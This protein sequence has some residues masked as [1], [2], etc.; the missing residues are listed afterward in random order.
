VTEWGRQRFGG[1]DVPAERRL[2]DL[3]NTLTLIK[4]DPAAN[5]PLL[6][7]L[8]D[9]PLPRERSLTFAP[10]ELRRRQL[11]ALTSWAMASAK[12]QPLVLGLED[13]HWADPTTL[14]LLRGIAERGAL[15]PLFVLITARPEFRPPWGIRSHHGMILLAPLDH[16]QVRD[17]VS[18]LAAQHALPKE[19]VD[20]VTERT[21]GVPLFVEEVT[22]LLLERGEQGGIQAI[23]PTLQQSLAARL[24]PLG[25][26]RELAQIG[27]VIGRG[28]S[29]GLLSEVV[30][31]AEAP[32]QAALEK[33]AE[34]DILLV[35]GLPPDSDYWFKHA[36]L[37]DAAYENL[38][39]SRRQALHRRV[40]E[41]LRDRFANTAVAEPEALAHHFTQAG[42]T[43]TAIE[44]WSKG[45]DQ[46]LR[47]SSFQEA[48][49]HL[50]KAIEMADKSTVATPRLAVA[51]G[52]TS[53]RLKLQNSY[54]RAVMWSE[55]FGSE[56]TKAAFTRAQQL[57]VGVND[58]D[59]LFATYYGL[60]ACSLY[61]G[62]M[63]GARETAENFRRE[64]V[65]AARVMEAAV[66]HRYLG[67]IYLMQG[68]FTE[69]KAHLQEALGIFDPE[70]DRDVKIHF[71][72][73]TDVAAMESLAITSWLLGEIGQAHRLIEQAVTR[74]V[75]SAHI[76]NLTNAY[77]FKGWL[78]VL[79][80]DA[81]AVLRTAAKMTELSQEYA[82]PS[83]LVNASLQSSWARFC[84]GDS[85]SAPKEFRRA[86]A[87]ESAKGIKLF[88]PTKLGHLAMMEA[89]SQG[90]GEALTRIDEALAL[91][92]ETGEHWSDAVLHGIRGDILLKH[93]PANTVPAEEAF[94]TAIAIAQEQKARS[95]E[96][97]AAMSM[98]RLWRDQGKRK[99]AHQL[100]API[101]GW[102]TEGFDTL[103]LKEAKALL[104]DLSP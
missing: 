44:W 18:E 75:E 25:P 16:Q 3:E 9:I 82:V 8:L 90:P 99:E 20:G 58:A 72:M 30:G 98:A 15:V 83:F 77:G 47:R 23:P 31:I 22:R 6:V 87:A 97:R 26:A 40:A 96:L 80:G 5:A 57:A 24:D 92:G 65:G 1:T 42:M 27:S 89:E 59:E 67:H 70:R 7:P 41:I 69:A 17:M 4:L 74:A 101:Y 56:E 73:D 103:D 21:G 36:L 51:T 13:I 19:I 34:A 76:P 2:A 64:A 43:D 29:Y 63:D 45:G 14:D 38:L 35:Q 33:L 71:G 60:W 95:F 39:K 61:R 86:M 28:F 93:D 37:Q 52:S 78:E 104:D 50:G 54:G 53:Q 55:G 79:R 12:V 88:W 85:E 62:K 48:K 46:A 32:L 10:E 11:A 91:A 102:F 49:S 100:L 68:Y 81:Q 94:L 66:A 84:L